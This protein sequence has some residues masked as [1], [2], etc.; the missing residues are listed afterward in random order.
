MLRYGL[1]AGLIPIALH[2]LHYHTGYIYNVY[3]PVVMVLGTYVSIIILLVVGF[4]R[5]RKRR[6]LSF[7]DVMVHTLVVCAIGA[8]LHTT[9]D[10]VLTSQ[11]D[12]KLNV[13]ILEKMKEHTQE[14]L[15]Q[16]KKAK[17]QGEEISVTTKLEAEKTIE[18]INERMEELKNQNVFV[19]DILVE[20]LKLYL[21]FGLIWGLIFGVIFRERS[22]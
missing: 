17:K 9:Y 18:R 21:L 8:V 6:S 10:Y 1:L 15:E 20:K 4:I 12:P 22:S 19:T 11:I 16:V 2:Q 13:R 3:Q 14:G 5:F 7:M